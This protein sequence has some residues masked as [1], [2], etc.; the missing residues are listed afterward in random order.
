MISI[1]TEV[2]PP[3]P[4][5]VDEVTLRWLAGAT[6][7]GDQLEVPLRLEGESLAVLHVASNE[8]LLERQVDEVLTNLALRGRMA[9]IDADR[10][11]SL[12]HW[13]ASRGTYQRDDVDGRSLLKLAN[14]SAG[15]TTGATQW[16]MLYQEEAE[17]LKLRIRLRCDGVAPDGQGRL[18]ADALL[19]HVNM[20]TRFTERARKQFELPSGTYAKRDHEITIEPERPLRS[21]QLAVNLEKSPGTVWIDEISVTPASDP[22]R[23]YVV[24]PKLDQWY[25]PLTT[26]RRHELDLRFAVLETEVKTLRDAKSVAVADAC[27]AISDLAAEHKEWINDNGLA[28]P[29]RRAVRE[30]DDLTARLSLVASMRMGVRGLEVDAPTVA[31][32]GEEIDVVVRAVGVEDRE[33]DYTLRA[34]PGWSSKDAGNGRFTL[35]VPH[36][37]LATTGRLTPAAVV[38]SP[39]GRTLRLEERASVRVVPVVEAAMR[40]G[41]VSA[42][43]EEVRLAV[44]CAN[45]GPVAVEAAIEAESPP[46]WRWEAA[47]GRWSIGAKSKKRIELAALPLPQTK[48]GRYAFRVKLSSPELTTPL[49]FS[50]TVFFLPESLNLLENPGFESGEANWA[51]SEG[52]YEIDTTDFH[53]GEQCLRMHNSSPAGRA[54]ALQ[55]ILLNQK[56]ARKI[57]VRGRAKAEKV[58]GHR[59][60]GFSIYVDIYYTDGT[61]L[62]GQTIE[63]ETGSTGWQHGEITIEPAKPIR[64]VN[65]YLLLRGHGGTAR[66]DDILVAEDP[67]ASE[68]GGEKGE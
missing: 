50:Q 19:C 30:L 35:T 18:V 41:D 34:S 29:C 5:V 36:D 3:V 51:R 60:R 37:A 2:L 66:F 15:A 43:G 25:E 23:E 13:P 52:G 56:A 48:P 49:D 68:R 33:V 57:I 14:E 24:D 4:V 10:P 28:N 20:K 11:Q 32:P 55:S 64:N 63:W 21:I 45:N 46:G 12:V 17:P 58:T 8:Q 27:L 6:V 59:G 16:V 65:V 7:K 42:S 47:T 62:Y 26:V 39:S 44:D 40:V 61:P 67:L 31:V 1:P 9:G 53:G 54:S 38:A 22:T